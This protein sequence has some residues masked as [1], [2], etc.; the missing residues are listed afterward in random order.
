MVNERPVLETTLQVQAYY[1]IMPLIIGCF[2][3]VSYKLLALL[4]VMLETRRVLY[5]KILNSND[6]KTV[7]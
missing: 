2:I 7:Y 1:V 5:T 4:I 3:F 6:V